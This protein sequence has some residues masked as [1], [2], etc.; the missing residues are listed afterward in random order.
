MGRLVRRRRETAAVERLRVQ[1]PDAAWEVHPVYGPLPYRFPGGY[2]PDFEPALPR[3]ALRGDPRRQQGACWHCRPPRYFYIDE[4]LHCR[5][6]GDRFTWP[7]TEQRHWYEELMLHAAGRPPSR[8]RPCRKE[9]QQHRALNTR[10]Q[11]MIA[12]ARAHPDDVITLLELAAVAADHAARLGSSTA[13]RGIAAARRARRQDP[14]AHAAHFWEGRCQEV[15]GRPGRAADCYDL[16]LQEAGHSHALGD[17]RVQAE[18]R[19]AGLRAAGG[20]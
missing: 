11:E 20:A 8:C 16:F 19:L 4:E 12:A 5:R 14:Q 1:H 2:D 17:L 10:L 9:H 7:A 6:C 18:D 13:D 15:A 3:G